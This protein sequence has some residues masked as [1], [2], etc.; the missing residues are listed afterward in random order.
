[1][2]AD[3]INKPSAK[4]PPHLPHGRW[5]GDVMGD[6]PLHDADTQDPKKKLL[7]ACARG[8]SCDFNDGERPEASNDAYTIPA[9]LIRFLALGGDSEHP[10]HE[11]GVRLSGCYISGELNLDNSHNICAI[12]LKNCTFEKGFSIKNSVVGE[13]ILDGSHLKG[14]DGTSSHFKGSLTA[15]DGFLNEGQFKFVKSKF[16]RDLNLQGSIFKSRTDESDNK[17]ISINGNRSVIL[18]NLYMG[19]LRDSDKREMTRKRGKLTYFESQ[20]ETRLYSCEIFGDLIL[21]C[22]KFTNENGIALDL[23]HAK[24]HGSLYFYYHFFDD[25]TIEPSEFT[26]TGHFILDNSIIYEISDIEDTWFSDGKSKTKFSYSLHGMRY[27]IF[28]A[29]SPLYAKLRENWILNQIPT[30][31]NS[32]EKKANETDKKEFFAQPWE[33]LIKVLREMG[34]PTEAAEVA[35]AKQVAMRKAGKIGN[36]EK[37]LRLWLLHW[38]LHKLYG[39]LAG[40][41]YRPLWLVG[42][43]VL[44]WAV[45]SFCFFHGGNQGYVGPSTALLNSPELAAQIDAKCGHHEELDHHLETYN[46]HKQPWAKCEAMPAEYTTFQPL[47]YSLDLILPL[48]DLQQESDWAPIVESAPGVN[49]PYGVFLRW[50]MWFTILFGWTASVMLVAIFGRLV[51]KD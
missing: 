42:W 34:H 24:I 14:F 47:L 7:S 36:P 49:M 2:G 17:S 20:G 40:Y 39:T 23:S 32:N 48:V 6:E 18:G 12:S 15:K 8:V 30:R 5:L 43:M 4:R 22:G 41:G 38:P 33:Q 45:A 44:L 50:L 19:A 29:R 25:K 37:K 3:V 26:I 35:I 27:E 21:T 28:A 16:D 13:I 31:F 46:Q 51:E 10:V 1:M 11:A 9:A